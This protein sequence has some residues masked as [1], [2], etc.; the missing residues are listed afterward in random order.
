MKWKQAFK[1]L[2]R[3]KGYLLAL[4]V[5][6][7]AVAVSGWLFVRELRSAEEELTLPEAVQ[8]AVLPSFPTSSQAIQS[9]KQPL[10]GKAQTPISDSGDAFEPASDPESAVSA[11]PQTAQPVRPVLARPVAGNVLAHYSMDKLAYNA[12]TRDWRT[13]AGM[14]IAAPEGSKV[15]AVADGT[16]L[17]VF[18]DDLLGQ[19]VTVE[20]EGGIVTHY[21]NLAEEVQVSAGDSVSAGQVL[22]TVGKTALSEIG[23]EAHL[24]F[25]VY[26]NNV[27]QDPEDYLAG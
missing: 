2:T 25:A 9:E 17:A 4:A 8:A 5:C 10:P 1:Q 27:P 24:H 6:L 22:G 21:A 14:D 20:H 11:A 26:K 15:C 23:S 16:V 18:T 12:T 3:E 7:G 13:H 19:T